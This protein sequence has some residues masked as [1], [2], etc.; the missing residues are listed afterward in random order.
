MNYYTDHKNLDE[1]C[2]KATRTLY[3]GN[4]DRD[5]K[6]EELRERLDK[7]YGDIVNVEVKRDQNGGL[8]C[9]NFTF[10][11]QQQ[12]ALSQSGGQLVNSTF[13][14]VEFTT[15]KSVIKA[16]KCMDGKCIGNSVIRLGFGK[17]KPSQYVWI[18]ELSEK[19][20]ETELK[21]I[22]KHYGSVKSVV[23][24]K[25]KGQALVYFSSIEHA[26]TCVQKL[27]AKKFHDKRVMIDFASNEF[28][29]RFD[30]SPADTQGCEN[31]EDSCN[32]NENL[33]MS[34][35]TTNTKTSKNSSNKRW[36]DMNVDEL[37]TVSSP[38]STNKNST[39]TTTTSKLHGTNHYINDSS[40]NN[41][42]HTQYTNYNNIHQRHHNSHRNDNLSRDSSPHSTNSIKYL[43]NNKKLN[44]NQHH[45]AENA[46][47]YYYS[48]K[49]I[50][51]ISRSRSRSECS[52]SD[53]QSR[54]KSNERSNNNN[55]KNKSP[56]SV[57]NQSPSIKKYNN[58]QMSVN[59]KKFDCKYLTVFL[60][61]LNS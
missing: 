2:S 37:E 17:I 28:K 44:S 23:I 7:K 19:M 49:R 42:L 48:N 5:I 6:E 60:M 29:K 57:D 39:T 56:L 41:S 11:T 18:D 27:R 55:R 43:N 25:S 40:S 61:R 26:K 38:S 52:S 31:N 3:I 53:S 32:E 22:C 51:S 36:P 50:S 45:N 16:I 54:S 4:L 20:S 13:A 8:G 47:R 10:Q 58:N 15:I 34:E 30:K 24:D 21:S 59:N 9:N 12:L 33:M 35:S 14:F 1:Y 46:T